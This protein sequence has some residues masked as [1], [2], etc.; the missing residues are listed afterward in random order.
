MPECWPR[1]PSAVTTRRVVSPCWL[2][3][4]PSLD[5][6]D[7]LPCRNG[8]LHIPTRQLR[9]PSAAFFTLQGL[10]FTYDHDAPRADAWL[11][12]LADLWP[13]DLES[14]SA[15][16]EWMGYLLTPRTDFQKIGML[17]GPKR[18]GKGTIGRV[19][20]LLLGDR[21]V[22]GPTLANM[23]EQFGLSVLLNKSVA[24][25]SDA[26]LSGRSDTAVIAERLLSISGEDTLSI[27]RKFLPD[28]NGKLATRFW[29]MT[30]ELPRIEDASGALASRFLVL[31]LT[32]SFYGCEDHALLG[33]FVPELPSILNW[34]LEGFDR[35]YARGRFVQPQ[36][37]DELIQEFEDLGSP[38]GAFLRERCEVGK[39]FEV[40]KDR[41]FQSWKGWC[42]ESG[43]D[44]AGSIQVFGRNLRA[45][46]PWLAES[47]PHVL[48]ARVRY[49]EGIRLKD[50][51]E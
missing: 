16:Q 9:P 12:F 22:C 49:F 36:S 43:R 25:I 5:P 10:D 37:S 39:G 44:H 6:R 11:Q 30:N 51:D 40:P 17:V 48:G 8:L 27:P 26:R 23:S 31:R 33:R 4:D 2:D 13:D 32:R 45:A 28:W 38:I 24:I 19:S 18:S 14:Q 47:R 1:N 15:L 50:G 3:D 20:R 29:L 42:A 34:A 21:H 7:I 46:V 35:L 41:L